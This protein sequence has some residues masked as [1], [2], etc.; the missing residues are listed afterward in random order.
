MFV[1]ILLLL[2]LISAFFSIS[3]IALTAARPR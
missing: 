3:E 1:L 2:I